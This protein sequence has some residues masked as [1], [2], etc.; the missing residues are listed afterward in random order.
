LTEKGREGLQISEELSVLQFQ[1]HLP[2]GHAERSFAQADKE[3]AIGT[4]LRQAGGEGNLRQAAHFQEK[5]RR[6]K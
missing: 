1:N 4:C 5:T 3:L 2:H 6:A